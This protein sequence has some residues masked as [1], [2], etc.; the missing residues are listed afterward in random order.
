[1]IRPFHNNKGQLVNIANTILLHSQ[2][3][4]QT[5]GVCWEKES[6]SVQWLYSEFNGN[7]IWLK[8]GHIWRIDIDWTRQR[9]TFLSLG[10]HW[11]RSC[12]LYPHNQFSIHF[13]ALWWRWGDSVLDNYKLW[14]ISSPLDNFLVNLKVYR[15]VPSLL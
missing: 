6:V 1:M 13:G 10:E 7:K 14:Q 4:L 11:H 5:F 3:K 15:L 9:N 8:P 2:R 12:Q